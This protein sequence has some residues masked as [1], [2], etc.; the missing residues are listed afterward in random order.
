VVAPAP[1]PVQRPHKPHH[2]T[3]PRRDADYLIDPFDPAER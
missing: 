1:A 3:L 2:K